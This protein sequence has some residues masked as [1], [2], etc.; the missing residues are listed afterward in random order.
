[1]PNGSPVTR[2]AHDDLARRVTGLEGQHLDT[3]LITLEQAEAADRR[4]RDHA[5]ALILGVLTFV[6]G[7]LAVTGILSLLHLGST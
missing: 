5:W 1:M 3:R 7:S 2:D 6:A 4:K